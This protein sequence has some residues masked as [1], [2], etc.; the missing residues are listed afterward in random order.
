MRNQKWISIVLIILI[1]TSILLF[2][3]SWISR[4]PNHIEIVVSRYNENLEWLSEE[5]FNH[6]PV[7]IYNKGENEDFVKTPNIRS[8]FKIPNVGR[9][10]H[11]YLYHVVKN[12]DNLADITIFLPGSCGLAH[13]HKRAK[14]TVIITENIHDTYF[15]D[16]IDDLYEK[17]KDFQLD[18][19]QS[20]D[21][22]NKKVNNEKELT[23]SNYRPF[24]VWFKHWFG[25]LKVTQTS[26]FG[27]FAV[28]KRH[29]LQ[30]PKEFYQKML[31]EISVSSNP[32]VG[33]YYERAW[34]AIF[35]QI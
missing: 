13:K 16:N 12:Y 8:I 23:P 11:S 31:D 24:G 27:I 3:Y 28:H 26:Y 10:T 34:S 4:T 21:G 15:N 18:N 14:D 19:W 33:H 9:E 17:Y 2:I 35:Y 25:D 7:I 5:P 32:E 30:R 22:L 1:I 29:I 6:H 20:S